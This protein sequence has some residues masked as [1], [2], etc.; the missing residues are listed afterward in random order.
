[1]V[2]ELEEIITHSITFHLESIWACQTN[3]TSYKYGEN[4]NIVAKDRKNLKQ[5]AA[6][7]WHW[8]SYRLGKNKTNQPKLKPVEWSKKNQKQ[9]SDCLLVQSVNWQKK[10]VLINNIY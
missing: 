4:T 8:G 7:V 3:L 6:V 10:A 5:H 1:M 2:I 9:R